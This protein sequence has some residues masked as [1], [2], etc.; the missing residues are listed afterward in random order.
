MRGAKKERSRRAAAT[1]EA[2]A[3]IRTK[4]VA[5]QRG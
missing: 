5:L 1:C 3:I 4:T 2:F